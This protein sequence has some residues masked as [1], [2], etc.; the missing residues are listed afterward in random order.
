MIRALA[1]LKPGKALTTYSPIEKELYHMSTRPNSYLS[2]KLQARPKADGHGIFAKEPLAKAELL[3]VFGGVVYPWEAF[4]ALPERERSLSIQV[5][6]NLFLAPD[7]IGEGDY[8]NHCCEPN[9]GLSGQ[10]A[11]VALRDI[12]PGEEV[13]FDYAMSD[14]T[15]YDEFDCQ[16]GAVHCRGRVTG[17]DWRI[18]ALQERYAGYFTPYV[19]RLIDASRKSEAP[20]G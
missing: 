14:A 11:L 1:F 18:P 10:I 7:L 4:M 2:P 8:V 19:Q 12:Q 16:C 13:C 6:E 9:A 5:E 3:A 20:R 15:P 17:D